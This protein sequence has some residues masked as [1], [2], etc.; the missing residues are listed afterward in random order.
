MAVDQLDA[1]DLRL[2]EAG[3]DGH[4]QI[5]RLGLL[6][7]DNLVD[8]VGLGQQMSVVDVIDA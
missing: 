8:L 6:A 1:E 5:G 7:L 3:R 2:R 4:L